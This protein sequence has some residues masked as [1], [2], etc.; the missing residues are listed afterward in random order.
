MQTALAM[1][2]RTAF[3][4][5]AQEAGRTQQAAQGFAAERKAFLFGEFFAETAVVEAGI[6]GARSDTSAYETLQSALSASRRSG[7]GTRQG[8]LARNWKSR[9]LAVVPLDSMET[10]P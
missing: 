10:S 4:G 1:S 8:S 5:R 9:S 2:G 3:A 7:A 6:G